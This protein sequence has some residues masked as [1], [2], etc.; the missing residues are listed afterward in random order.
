ISWIDVRLGIRMLIKHPALTLVGGL[1][2]AVGIAISVGFYTFSAAF[3]YPRLPLDEG[4][5][6][7]AL[8]NRDVAVD[9]EERRSLHDFFTWREELGS[10]EDLAAFRTVD[11]NLFAGDGPPELV[12]VAEMTASG[13]RLARVPPLLG[14]YFVDEDE[15]EGAPRVLVIGH[16]VWRN[17]FAGDSAV[18]GRD[19]RL[20]GVV[21][22]VVGV[23][24][25]GFAF[26]ENH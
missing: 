7:V 10:V 15:R 1:G 17:A 2:L 14:R 21:H 13:F 9:N 23:M 24:P 25:E 11:R 20:G 5:R 16:G 12:Q 18:V 19:V 22:T 6:V 4:E 8:E 26:P 3:I